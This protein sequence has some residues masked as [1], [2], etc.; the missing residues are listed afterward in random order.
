MPPSRKRAR[1]AP[2]AE[3]SSAEPA[4]V[5]VGGGG[6]EWSELAKLWRAGELVDCVHGD[7]GAACVTEPPLQPLMLPE[8]ASL[9]ARSCRFSQAMF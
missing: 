1:S 8:L 6:G 7:A 3:S 4:A 9:P 5:Q 2:A